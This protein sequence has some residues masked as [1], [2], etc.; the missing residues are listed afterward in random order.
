MDPSMGGRYGLERISN[1]R[2][3]GHH[4]GTYEVTVTTSSGQDRMT[5]P[6]LDTVIVGP[7]W[8]TAE[9]TWSVALPG[10]MAS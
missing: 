8:Q 6:Y 4:G 7:D 10:E 2:Y 3:C 9:L 5:T 1:A